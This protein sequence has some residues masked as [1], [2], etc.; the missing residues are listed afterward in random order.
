MSPVAALLTHL[1]RLGVREFCVAAGAR[2]AQIIAALQASRGIKIWSFFE[3]R[4]AAFFALGRM[5]HDRAPVAVVTTSGTAAAELLPAIIEAHYQGLPLIA[6]TADRPPHYRGSGAPQAIEQI[7]LFGAYTPPTLEDPELLAD[8]QTLPAKPLHINLCLEE[9]LSPADDSI[10]FTAHAAP[11]PQAPATGWT[12]DHDTLI[13]FLRHDPLIL[14][15]GLHPREAA[16][17]WTDL[18]HLNFPIVAEATANLH[19]HPCVITGGEALL[20]RLNPK[21]VLRIGAVPSWRWWRDLEDRPDIPVLNLTATGFPGLARKENVTTLPLLDRWPPP[22]LSTQP[23]P[24]P[25]LAEPAPLSEQAWMNHL[26]AA[27]PAGARLFLGNSLP[28][29]E[30]NHIATPLPRDTV[31]YANR[32]ANGIDGL[33]ST[34]LGI[35]AT[36]A[37]SWLI[38]GDLS[39]LYDLA[40]PWIIPQL[41]PGNRRLV[42]INNGGGKIFSRAASLRALPDASRAIIE[43]RHTLTF[44]PWAELWSI[45]CRRATEPGHLLALPD[46]PVLIE[47]IPQS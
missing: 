36:A 11:A 2:N 41:P 33:V 7:G 32:G 9:G 45:P 37:E 23:L 39:A 17:L 12:A 28:I 46:G 1:A 25:I 3:E 43:N 35:S 8:L 30:F 14:A 27:I 19:G 31:C 20:T 5:M 15:A 29:R 4:C 42:V 26:A 18:E 22:L 38:L 10:D 24:A 47:V 34:F 44:A 13:D 6:V 16:S 40:A 21:S